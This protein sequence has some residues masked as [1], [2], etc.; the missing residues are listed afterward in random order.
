MPLKSY[1]FALLILFFSSIA[2]AGDGNVIPLNINVVST[3][4]ISGAGT[5]RI[6]DFNDECEPFEP[7]F[8]I[9]QFEKGLNSGITNTIKVCS[10]VTED[11]I[12]DVRNDKSGGTWFE[13]FSWDDSGLRFDLNSM[14]AIF[15]CKI[16]LLKGSSY[17]ANCNCK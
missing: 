8:L 5:F 4:W 7:C 11:G 14:R 13:N 17:V 15:N 16:N 1:F 2:T 6:I 12:I 10:V 9:Q 3:K